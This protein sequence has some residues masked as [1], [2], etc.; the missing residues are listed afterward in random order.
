MRSG[1]ADGGSKGA[2]DL[3]Q[4]IELSAKVP[5]PPV[6]DWFER[7]RS[8]ALLAGLGGEAKTGVTTVE[9][10]AFAVQAVASLR[11]A[12]NAGWNRPDELKEPDFDALRSRDDFKKL[13]AEVEANSGPKAK[14][15]D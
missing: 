4:S 12:I 9:A 15:G 7:S 3:R 1:S 13:L 8:L 10:S 14:G 6:P 5:S 2:A 11:D